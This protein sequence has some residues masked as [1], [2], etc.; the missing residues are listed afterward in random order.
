MDNLNVKM[1]RFISLVLTLA[2][3]V[4]VSAKF[5]VMT[6]SIPRS[7]FV[8]VAE[9]APEEMHELVFSVQQKNLVEFDQML[10][11]RSTPGNPLFQKWFTFEEVGQ[12]TSNPEGAKEVKDWL[13]ANGITVSWES[14]HQDYIKASAPISKWEQLLDSKFYQ[15]EDHSRG[16]KRFMHRAEQYSLPAEVKPHLFAVFNTVQVPPVFKPK[17]QRLTNSDAEPSFKTSFTVKPSKDYKTLRGKK[18]ATAVDGYVTVQF[19]NEFYDITSNEGDA[20]MSQSVFATDGRGFSPTDL[21]LFQDYYSL[22]AQAC[23]APY[24]YSVEDCG[25]YC[26]KGSVDVQYMMGVAQ[27][28]TTIYW[29]VTEDQATDP[30]VAWVTEIANSANPPQTNAITYGSTEQF[31]GVDI[32]GAFNT[33]AMKLTSMG[34]TVTASS[35]ESGAADSE[36]F[37]NYDS[38]SNADYT[39]W[40]VSL[41]AISLAT[42]TFG[43]FIRSMC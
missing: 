16:V 18:S 26:Y 24:G 8:K 20:T 34:V 28:T 40:T 7:T 27:Q 12:L 1:T 4:V 23:E 33:E 22:P 13:A 41:S 6:K 39:G 21:T 5:H 11:E 9:S 38:S 15:W 30:F 3:L 43:A 42:V 10:L 25:Y 17:Y 36:D 19:L 32:L 31:L 2:I 35:G 29:Y 14:A 37:C